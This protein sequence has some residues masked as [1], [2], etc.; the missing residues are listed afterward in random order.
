MERCYQLLRGLLLLVGMLGVAGGCGAVPALPETFEVAT[1]AELRVEVDAGTGPLG[2]A[3]GTWSIT[4]VADPNDLE[5]TVNE[6]TPPGPYGG[7]LSGQRLARPPVGERIFLVQFEPEGRMVEV[8]ENRYFLPEIYGAT[9]PIGGDWVAATLPG[10]QFRSESYGTQSDGRFG[11]AE[12]VN[13]RSGSLFLGQATLY[14]WGTQTDDQIT[15]TFGYVIDFTDGA[16]PALGT[17]ADQYPIA[18]QRIE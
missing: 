13:V 8:T 9:V 6:T 18:G 16:V 11:L 5:E 3:G 15:G 2:L 1:S 7:L 10:V 14:A 17:V 4:R 12:I